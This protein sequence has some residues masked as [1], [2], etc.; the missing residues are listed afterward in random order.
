MLR[1]HNRQTSRNPKRGKFW[2]ACDYV[3]KGEGKKCLV[4]GNRG[5]KK[6]RGKKCD[7]LDVT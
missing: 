2:C 4:C 7:V 1:K 5:G 3:Y 6:R